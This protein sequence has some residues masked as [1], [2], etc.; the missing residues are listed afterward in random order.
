MVFEKVTSI[1]DFLFK[2][3][4]MGDAVNYHQMIKESNQ[5]VR[6]SLRVMAYLFTIF[7]VLVLMFEIRSFDQSSFQIYII[8]VSA[9]LI[10]LFVLIMV[11]SKIAVKH[12]IALVHVLLLTIIISFA[13]MIFI[14]P[15]TLLVNSQIVGLIIFTSA[16]FLSWDI[17]NQIM[18]AI[19]YT[20]VFTTAI[21]LNDKAVNFLP[22][23]SISFA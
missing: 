2:K 18:V 22:N 7:G 6:K 8:R 15:K 12:L 11:I 3:E 9:S 13:L 21:L 17:K 19:Y 20:V 23:N 1:I 4:E 14:L 10:S 5:L 16:L